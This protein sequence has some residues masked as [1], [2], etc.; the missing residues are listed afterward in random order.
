MR[1]KAPIWLHVLHKVHSIQRSKLTT[2]A[3]IR[4]LF[5]FNPMSSHHRLDISAH[6]TLS[7]PRTSS[8]SF[9]RTATPSPPHPRLITLHALRTPCRTYER[10]APIPIPLLLRFAPHIDRTSNTFISSAHM[11]AGGTRRP[12]RSCSSRLAYPFTCPSELRAFPNFASY[13]FVLVT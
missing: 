11:T 12:S 5:S 2:Y 1:I 7:L 13:D 3:V 6:S 8:V 4:Y 10:T 9:H